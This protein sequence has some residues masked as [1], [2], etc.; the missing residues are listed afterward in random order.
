MNLRMPFAGEY[1]I[2][3][4]FGANPQDYGGKGHSGVDYATPVGVPILASAAGQ[5]IKAGWDQADV[6]RGYGKHVRI[7]HNGETTIYGHLSE[8]HVQPGQQV[9]AGQVLGLSG[10]TGRSTGPHLHWELRIG[11]S[12]VDPLKYLGE[13]EPEPA[14]VPLPLPA[15]GLMRVLVNLRVRKAASTSAAIITTL[16]AG[17]VVQVR[18]MQ[19]VGADEWA[20]LAPGMW[21]AARYQ[22]ERY[23]EPA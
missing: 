13:P 20:E 17:L 14:P 5:V 3:Q 1:W 12:P 23:M 4:R 8:I 2:S 11:S 10:N 9:K 19:Q 21:S 6:R 7:D 18:A 22:G 15:A 16:P